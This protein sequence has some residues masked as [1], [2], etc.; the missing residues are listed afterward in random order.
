MLLADL[1]PLVLDEG[2]TMHSSVIESMIEAGELRVVNW[3]R[4]LVSPVKFF[5][6]VYDMLRL[7]RD[8]KRADENTVNL[9]V[10]VKPYSALQRPT[11]QTLKARNITNIPYQ[12]I[13]AQNQNA[14]KTALSLAGAVWAQGHKVNIQLV[15]ED[16][17]RQFTAPLVD[18]PTYPWKH[19]QRYY[20]DDRIEQEFLH[21]TRPRMSLI[22]ALAPAMGER[23]YL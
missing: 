11:T 20:R 22:G 21:R 7:V 9:L 17:G 19:A 1:V 15:N 10:E 18:L 8:D 12:S 3:V 14:M 13:M 23:E 6:V 2:C 16:G 5:T 4:N